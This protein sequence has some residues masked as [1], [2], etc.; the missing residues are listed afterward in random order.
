MVAVNGGGSA[1]CACEDASVQRRSRRL[2]CRSKLFE[3][4][5]FL[6]FTAGRTAQ[7]DERR[8]PSYPAAAG[9]QSGARASRSGSAH[10]EGDRRTTSTGRKSQPAVHVTADTVVM[11]RWLIHGDSRVRIVARG[12]CWCRVP[13]DGSCRYVGQNSPGAQHSFM[14][15]QRK[16]S[17][18]YP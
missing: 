8:S 10:R 17:F 2:H 5:A 12:L 1:I 4:T 15:S 16:P 11:R 9:R 14:G 13:L 6:R 7:H 3:V 18:I